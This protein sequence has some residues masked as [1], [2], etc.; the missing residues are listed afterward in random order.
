[1][2]RTA[3]VGAGIIGGN[4]AA[5]IAR[6]PDVRLD[7]LVDVDPQALGALARKYP[8]AT[9]HP[10][11]AEALDEVDL[12]VVCTPSGLH[13]E[14]VEAA[15]AAG[16][17]VLV[18]KPLD[19]SLA[20]A[21]R[22]AELARDAAG[23]G[24]VTSVVSQ[25][26][27][28]PGSVAVAAAVSSGRLGRLTSAVASVPWWRTQD[29]YDQAAWRGT[30]ALDGGVVMNQAVHTVDLL[31][32]L[33][34]PPIEVYAQ[35][36]RLAHQRIEVEDVAVATLR[37]ASGALAVLHAT[38]AAAP[39]LAVR[40]QVHGTGGSAVVED[41]ELRYLVDQAVEPPPRGD[42][43]F[44]VGHLR[45]Y[46]DLVAAIGTGRPPGVTA[47]DGLLAVAVVVAVYVSATLSRPVAFDDVLRG[48]FDTIH[49]GSV[50]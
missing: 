33:F 44:V 43:A 22:L 32:W 34:G 4:H 28:D 48:D 26:R 18:E 35:S 11:L 23:R 36:A 6:H 41:D 30:W 15:L 9:R 49:F 5:A 50:S 1:V 2:I 46:E 38:T 39:G 10:T 14:P 47:D 19:V 24:V 37:F 27:F 16:K 13:A 42:D 25:H 29:Y 17:H 20:R 12:V 8:D 31:I 45:Q 40:L 3:I 7:A 21:R